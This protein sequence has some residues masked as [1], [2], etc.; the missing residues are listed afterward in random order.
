MSCSIAIKEGESSCESGCWDSRDGSL[1]NDASPAWLSFV[2]G[3]VEEIVK[4]EVLQGWV[5][6][7]GIGDVSEED[8][9]VVRRSLSQCQKM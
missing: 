3:L 2:D 8:A 7:E 4:E 6:A 9:V 1:G 5:L